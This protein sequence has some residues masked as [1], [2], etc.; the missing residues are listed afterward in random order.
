MLLLQSSARASKRVSSAAARPAAAEVSF[1]AAACSATLREAESLRI[2]RSRS[3]TSPAL[4]V[5]SSARSLSAGGA[6]FA[7]QATAEKSRAQRASLRN[8]GLPARVTAPVDHLDAALGRAP[9]RGIVCDEDDGEP[10]L[11]AELA[12]E[13][14][15]LGVRGGV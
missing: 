5:S 3:D 10:E 12:E 11:G 8:G 13:V 14:H 15:D 1:C 6:A 7:W 9:H 2:A 4:P